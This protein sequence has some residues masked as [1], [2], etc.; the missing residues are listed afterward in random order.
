MR[1]DNRPMTANSPMLNMASPGWKLTPCQGQ[2][3]DTGSS[4]YAGGG[5]RDR[6]AARGPLVVGQRHLVRS[7]LHRIDPGSGEALHGG[8]L[9][10]HVVAIEARV[11]RARGGQRVVEAEHHVVVVGE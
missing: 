3:Q 7:E 8:L 6:D 11:G 2:E 10:G 1:T 9:A 4:A 5:S